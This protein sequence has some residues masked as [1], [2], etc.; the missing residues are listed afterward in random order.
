MAANAD[1]LRDL[2]DFRTLVRFCERIN[3]ALEGKETG[4]FRVWRGLLDRRIYPFSGRT[5]QEELLKTLS[6][7][8]F[9]K[10]LLGDIAW[11]L[12]HP[13]CGRSEEETLV[14]L[15]FRLQDDLRVATAHFEY[16]IRWKNF[17]PNFARSRL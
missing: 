16:L 17:L 13:L 5:L 10:E 6:D 15:A 14:P 9:C 2:L 1:F 7:I 12:S 4:D 8:N 3:K 11:A